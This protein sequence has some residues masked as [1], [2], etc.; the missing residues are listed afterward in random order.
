MDP[1]KHLIYKGKEFV[2]RGAQWPLSSE[3]SSRLSPD[4]GFLA[5]NSWDGEMRICPELA[6]GCQD[7]LQGNYY[8]EIYD[9]ASASLALSLRGQFQGFDPED[10]FRQSAWASRDLY[11]LPLDR[12]PW[13]NRFMLCDLQQAPAKAK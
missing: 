1:E 9:A 6:L 3:D 11:V 8:I 5:V 12:L 2:R 4:G 10:L 13:T 7:H